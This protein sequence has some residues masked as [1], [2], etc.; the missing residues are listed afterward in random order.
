[1]I[2]KYLVVGGGF[3]GLSAAVH[4]AKNSLQVDL[5]EASPKVGGR[6]YSFLEKSTNTLIDNGQHILMG[7]YTDTLNFLKIIDADQNL[8]YQNNLEV[9]FLKKDFTLILVSASLPAAS[10]PNFL[11]FQGS[12]PT[13]A[14]IIF[15][16]SGNLP[17]TKAIYFF[18]TVLL[19]NCS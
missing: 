7:C 3:A 19:R 6:A 8:A 16:E 1:M 13:G 10:T 15:V 12:L 4:L 5:I 11:L 2:K 14:L 18:F 17:W 9:N